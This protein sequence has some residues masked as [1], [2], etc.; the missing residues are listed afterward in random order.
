M[1]PE[2]IAEKRRKLE[3]LRRARSKATCAGVLS[4]EIDV[5]RETEI[6]DLEEELRRLEKPAGGRPG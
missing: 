3:E 2:Q 5:R 1:K 4:S 6:E